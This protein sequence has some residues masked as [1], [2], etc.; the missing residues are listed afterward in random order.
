VYLPLEARA[1]QKA[2]E[3]G[4]PPELPNVQHAAAEYARAIRA[5][6]PV[7][8]YRLAGMSY[9]G[10]VAFETARQLAARGHSVELV[11][12]FDSVLPAS[13]SLEP[14]RWVAEHLREFARKGP[15]YVHS[16][17]RRRWSR[18]R[19]AGGAPRAAASDADP[20]ADFARESMY[21]RAIE[22]YERTLGSYA[23]EVVLYRASHNK[24]FAG[25]TVAHDLGWGR[26]AQRLAIV[27][28]E[29]THTS[30][31][32]SPS[33]AADLAARSRARGA[34]GAAG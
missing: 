25:Y 7:G 16:R 5:R 15:A 11:A 10:I 23:G 21:A 12:L 13:L 20:A 31:L 28:V 18:W 14:R 1:E 24:E 6:D 27:E 34:R 30:I 9:G 26:W 19:V 29:G 17:V 22:E 33:V 8:P 3:L 4:L 32:D 2:E